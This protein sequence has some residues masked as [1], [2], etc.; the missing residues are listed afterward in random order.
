MNSLR[1]VENSLNARMTMKKFMLWAAILF[2]SAKFD[3][4]SAQ[5]WTRTSAPTNAWTAV[6]TS[7]D[8]TRL[9]AVGG[10]FIY[11]STN[12][13]STWISNNAPMAGWTEVA[14]SS[15]GTKLAA[16]VGFVYT[17]LGTAWTFAFKPGSMQAAN[18][19]A[20]SAGETKLV[21]ANSLLFEPLY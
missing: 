9:V 10:N 17:I 4:A 15:D 2:C 1:I 13:G 21:V 16:G 18:A 6:A 7:A 11:T 20:S 19:I 3:F 5:S 12:Y 14:S 8:G